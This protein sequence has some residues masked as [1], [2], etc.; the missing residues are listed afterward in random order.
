MA[1]FLKTWFRLC[2]NRLQKLLLCLMTAMFV[3]GS[4]M[5][6][7]QEFRGV[8]TMLSEDDNSDLFVVSQVLQRCSGLYGALAKF[9]PKSDPQLAQLKETS[10]AFFVVFF[11]KSVETLNAKKQNTPENNL[12]EVGKDIPY[13]VDFYYGQLE[14]SQLNTGSIFSSWTEREFTYCNRLQKSVLK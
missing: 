1:I 6:N 5:V 7:A 4:S 14:A 2:M 10:A 11:E 9:L 13:Y 3:S 8:F 12:K